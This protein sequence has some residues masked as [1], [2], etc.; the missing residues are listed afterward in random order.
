MR[1]FPKK[2][3]PELMQRLLK[4]RPLQSEPSNDAVAVFFVNFNIVYKN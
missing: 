1:V 4:T 2:Y 3:Q